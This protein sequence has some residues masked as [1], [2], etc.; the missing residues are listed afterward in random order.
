MIEAYFCVNYSQD[1]KVTKESFPFFSRTGVQV[2]SRK[3][4]PIRLH[5]ADHQHPP[6]SA[7]GHDLLPS[8]HGGRSDHLAVPASTLGETTQRLRS[9]EFR[10]SRW[11]DPCLEGRSRSESRGFRLL[12]RTDR[13]SLLRVG[14]VGHDAEREKGHPFDDATALYLDHGSVGFQGRNVSRGEKKGGGA[15]KEKKAGKTTVVFR[16]VESF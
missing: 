1:S 4:L 8:P 6:R 5:H 11:L 10:F 3:D 7:G 12:Q 9:T 2:Y 13:W 14:G 16:Y 15:L